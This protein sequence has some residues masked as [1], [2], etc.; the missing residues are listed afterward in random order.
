MTKFITFEGG[1]GSGKTTMLAMIS[2]RLRDEGFSVKTCHDP[3]ST[4][5]AINLRPLLLDKQYKICREAELLLYL[6]ARAELVDKIIRPAIDRGQIDFI[7][8]D[9]FYDS[10]AVYQGVIR[11]WNDIRA[12]R[13]EA[14]R[15]ESTFLEIMHLLFSGNIHPDCTF[16]FDVNPVL[17]LNRS[18]GIEIDEGRWEEMGVETHS[19]INRAFLEL[20]EMDEDRFIIIDANQEKEDVF[21]DLFSYFMEEGLV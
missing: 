7:L 11:G 16:L 3:G 1:E 8:C 10:T 13:E 12:W 14:P 15:S 20:A 17:G 19:K 9:R 4:N 21:T 6:A 18:K 2:E 5:I